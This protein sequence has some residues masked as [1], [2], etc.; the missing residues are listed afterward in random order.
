MPS[1]AV[2]LG[3]HAVRCNALLP[4]TIRTWPSGEDLRDD[5]KRGAIEEKIRLDRLNY[6]NNLKKPAVFLACEAEC[7]CERCEHSGG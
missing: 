1:C 6:I 4:D 5:A 3:P 7:L 2:A